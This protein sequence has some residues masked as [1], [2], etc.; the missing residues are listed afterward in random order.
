MVAANNTLVITSGAAASL[1]TGS[2]TAMVAVFEATADRATVATA[3]RTIWASGGSVGDAR[4][5]GAHPDREAALLDSRR[6]REASAEE[7]QR[8]PRHRAERPDLEHPPAAMR[9]AEQEQGGG[10]RDPTLDVRGAESPG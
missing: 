1:S 10:H 2:I 4:E 8:F 6:H 7:Q 9:P 3:A 5:L